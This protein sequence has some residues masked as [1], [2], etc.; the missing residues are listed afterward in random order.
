MLCFFYTNF[1]SVRHRYLGVP[2]DDAELSLFFGE[3][4]VSDPFPG[5]VIDV[6]GDGTGRI[7]FAGFVDVHRDATRVASGFAGAHTG[8]A[9]FAAWFVDAHGDRPGI[10]AHCGTRKPRIFFLFVECK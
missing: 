1:F 6:H 8:T 4:A 5:G 2:G 10:L 3:F 9:A 7:A